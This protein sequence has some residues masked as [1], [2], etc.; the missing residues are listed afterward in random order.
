MAPSTSPWIVAS[1]A[2]ALAACGDDAAPASDTDAT[3]SSTSGAEESTAAE[4]ADS[5]GEICEESMADHTPATLP[6][7]VVISIG[8]SLLTPHPV[9]QA[10]LG[11][12][13][14]T[15]EDNDVRVA[16]IAATDYDQ[17]YAEDVCNECSLGAECTDPIAVDVDPGVIEPLGRFAGS[18]NAYSCLFREPGASVRHFVAF[19]DTEPAPGE[20]MEFEGFI[21]EQMAEAD[22]AFHVAFM[23]GCSQMEGGMGLEP[24]ANGLGGS[25][26]NICDGVAGVREFLEDIAAP[27]LAC[28]W[29]IED[30]GPNNSA[31]NLE[32]VLLDMPSGGEM[33]MTR[34]ADGLCTDPEGGDPP[35]EW[36]VSIIDGVQSVRMCPATCSAIQGN[37]EPGEL[38]FRQEFTCP[39]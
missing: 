8:S 3:G 6:A 13:G 17:I 1:L 15:Y 27:R 14:Q 38:S 5:S 32:L 30:P 23:L 37:W 29:P 26:G 21:N 12:V 2:V 34:V 25:S 22:S 28:G 4:P 9:L 35:F 36:F 39:A 31:D 10:A 20:L 11:D 19:T 7:D 18:S 24:V 16:L 33:G